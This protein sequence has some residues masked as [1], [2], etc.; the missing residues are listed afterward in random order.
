MHKK[1]ESSSGLEF[2]PKP[3]TTLQPGGTTSRKYSGLSI[4]ASEIAKIQNLVKKP[5]S[6]GGKGNLRKGLS[7]SEVTK[8]G[9]VAEINQLRLRIQELEK[10]L[11]EE[12]EG[13]RIAEDKLKM[14][15]EVLQS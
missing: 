3:K 11:E 2:I 10:R 1:S 5:Q 8:G 15:T 14:I 7:Q 13:R 12:M 9:D 6:G 4:P